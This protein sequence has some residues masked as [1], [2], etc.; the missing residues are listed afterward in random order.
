[1]TIKGRLLVK[2]LYIG[3]FLKAKNVDFACPVSRDV[4]I[5]GPK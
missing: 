2:I 5:G 4:W 1:M 3:M